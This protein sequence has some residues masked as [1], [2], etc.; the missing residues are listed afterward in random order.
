MQRA[1]HVGGYRTSLP[2]TNTPHTELS[3]IPTCC[4]WR[5]LLDLGKVQ[6]VQDSMILLALF[7]FSR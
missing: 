5:H 2:T 4:C 1:M 3:T 6:D 7:H